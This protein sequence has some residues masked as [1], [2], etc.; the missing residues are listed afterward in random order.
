MAHLQGTTRMDLEYVCPECGGGIATQSG[1]LV[2]EMCWACGG[3]GRMTGGQL[4]Q[5]EREL[6]R[7]AEASQ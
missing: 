5:Y 1:I 7:R 3:T 6:W 2:I 4:T